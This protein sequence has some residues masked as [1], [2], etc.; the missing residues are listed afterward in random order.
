MIGWKWCK[1]HETVVGRGSGGRRARDERCC[2][3]WVS[4][5]L[6]GEAMEEAMEE[7]MEMEEEEMESASRSTRVVLGTSYNSTPMQTPS[8]PL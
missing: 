3:S 7:E 6:E 2:R 8:V 1:T 5:S 4:A